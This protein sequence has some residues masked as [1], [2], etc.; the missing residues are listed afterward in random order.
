MTLCDFFLGGSPGLFGTSTW[1]DL[2][3]DDRSRLGTIVLDCGW[4]AGAGASASLLLTVK[5]SNSSLASGTWVSG[6]GGDGNS[7]T[8][9]ADSCP[10]GFVVE[11]FAC[12]ACVS[13][14]FAVDSSLPCE[15]FWFLGEV[16]VD[17]LGGSSILLVQESISE[18]ARCNLLIFRRLLLRDSSGASSGGMSYAE[19]RCGR[20]LRALP[21][22]RWCLLVCDSGCDETFRDGGVEAVGAGLGCD[23]I[24]GS[25]MITGWAGSE[26][27]RAC[28][29]NEKPK[30]TSLVLRV[31]YRSQ[32]RA[33]VLWFRGV[34][35]RTQLRAGAFVAAPLALESIRYYSRSIFNDCAR[36]GGHCGGTASRKTRGGGG[37]RVESPTPTPAAVGAQVYRGRSIFVP[38]S[39][40]RSALHLQLQSDSRLSSHPSYSKH[41][42]SLSE[43]AGFG[44]ATT[45]TLSRSLT[46]GFASTSSRKSPANTN[47]PP[48]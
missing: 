6:V 4:S 15:I 24:T 43:W 20:S 12:P 17:V 22:V 26:N 18:V 40:Q 7:G 44:A 3:F 11:A 46:Q 2:D 14:P 16:S 10:G 27:P 35:A 9:S 8:L 1:G 36:T 38:T 34:E 25:G 13:G 42:H 5:F 30:S 19:G 45:M 28:P 48:I 39:P 37:G 21:G 41:Q 47:L 29:P 33:P 31:L 23:G 32:L